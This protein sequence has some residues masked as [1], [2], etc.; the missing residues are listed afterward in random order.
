MTRAAFQASAPKPSSVD[1]IPVEF[2]GYYQDDPYVGDDANRPDGF[3]WH[4]AQWAETIE[5]VAVAPWDEVNRVIKSVAQDTDGNLIVAASIDLS[6]FLISNGY[7]DEDRR[8]MASLLR[9]RCRV[10]DQR[11]VRARHLSGP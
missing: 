9:D 7:R 10:L 2:T 5:F 11:K 6:H 4:T 1:P 8:R 3:D